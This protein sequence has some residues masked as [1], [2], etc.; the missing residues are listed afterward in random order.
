LHYCCVHSI[1]GSS[2]SPSIPH[3]TNCRYLILDGSVWFLL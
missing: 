2:P 3:R 1:L